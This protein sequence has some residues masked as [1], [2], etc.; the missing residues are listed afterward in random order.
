MARK[1]PK[2]LRK[3]ESLHEMVEFF[4]THDMGEYWEQMPEAH[5]DINIKTRKHLVAIDE[6]IVPKLSEIAKSRKVSSE[7]LINNWLRE[8]IETSKR[9]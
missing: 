5:F 9:V 4:D 2:S 3:L 7:R 1:K 8:K 6:A